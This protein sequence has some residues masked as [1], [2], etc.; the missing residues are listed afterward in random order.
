MVARPS[1]RA[2]LKTPASVW[3]SRTF[4]SAQVP[5][6]ATSSSVGMFRKAATIAPMPPA[7]AISL[8]T[9]SVAA[10]VRSAQHALRCT[11]GESGRI[12]MASKTT[13]IAPA[14]HSARRFGS[15]L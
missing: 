8:A 3:S 4:S 11:S 9:S 13:S 14:S 6:R 12:S 10:R 5:K 15:E 2:K 1:L 7:A